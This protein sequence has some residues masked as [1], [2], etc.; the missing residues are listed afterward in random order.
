VQTARAE[1]RALGLELLAERLVFLDESGV[2]LSMA[3]FCARAQRGQRAVGHVPKN[4]GDSVTLCAGLALRGLIAPL[5]L[6][7]SMNGDVFEA[8]VEQF[9]VPELRPGDLVVMDNLS[10]HKRASVRAIIEQ[11]GAKL[12]FLP[13]YSPDFSPIEPAWSKVK[14]LLRRSA[15]R[16]YDALL[17][18]AT[19][20][21]RAITPSDARG[22]FRLCGYGPSV[23]KT[24]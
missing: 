20:A 3:R 12:L 24:L 23:R 5:Y 2:N 13:P 17:D 21:L 6:H 11:A 10:A 15:A 18:A 16:T 4:W 8:Y 14:A 7:G 22:W 19:A 9:L 1:F